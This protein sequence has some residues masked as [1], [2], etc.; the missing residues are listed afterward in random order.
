MVQERA[1][2]SVVPE[3]EREYLQGFQALLASH[4]LVYPICQSKSCAQ[5]QCQRGRD[6]K[7]GA[8][9]VDTGR[10]LIGNIAKVQLHSPDGELRLSL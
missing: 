6:K 9:G 8:K 7:V 4:L 3:G 2:V 10:P 5:A 1:G